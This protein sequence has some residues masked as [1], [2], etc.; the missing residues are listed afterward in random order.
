M[1]VV[2]ALLLLCVVSTTATGREEA[3]QQLARYNPALAL[4]AALLWGVIVAALV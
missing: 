1:F 2:V 3:R 4:I